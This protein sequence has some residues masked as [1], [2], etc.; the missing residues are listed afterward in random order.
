MMMVSVRFIFAS[1]SSGGRCRPGR[2]L[3]GAGWRPVVVSRSPGGVDGDVDRD[4]VGDDVEHRRAGPRLFDDLAQLLGRGVALDLE[5]DADLLVAVAD[6]VRQSEDAPQVDVTL[7]RRLDGGQLHAAG[8]GDVGDARRQTG[9]QTVEQDLDRGRPLV[10]ADEHLGV[11]AVVLEVALVAVRAT[12]S[13]E[14]LDPATAVGAGLP[15]VG[16]PELEL[17]QLGLLTDHVDGGEQVGRVDAVERLGLALFLGGWCLL[18][19]PS[20]SFALPRLVG[21]HPG[22]RSR[23]G[24]PATLGALFGSPTGIRQLSGLF[25]GVLRC[26]PARCRPRS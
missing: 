22:I 3:V 15:L 24:K 16:R 12:G 9:C 13:V 4:T 19:F 23:P 11:V 8:G 6:L 2:W 14:G 7:D 5:V 17:G 21:S 1:S 20:P 10:L 26:A 25:L 18:H